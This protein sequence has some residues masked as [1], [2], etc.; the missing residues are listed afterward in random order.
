MNGQAIRTICARRVWDS[1]GRPTVEA[2]VTLADGAV[3]RAI[4]PAGAS[5][6]TR[7]ALELRDGT[8]AFGGLDVQRAVGARATGTGSTGPGMGMM[9]V[10]ALIGSALSSY[11]GGFLPAQAAAAAS[12]AVGAPSSA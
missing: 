8:A 11:C 12:I 9:A 2:E 4:V 5:K 6:G 7:E 3:G 10:S 1:R